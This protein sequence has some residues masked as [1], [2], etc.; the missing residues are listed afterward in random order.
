M[1][2][3]QLSSDADLLDTSLREWPIPVQRQERIISYLWGKGSTYRKRH[4]R[5]YFEYYTEQC[6]IATQ[7]YQGLLVVKTHQHI[8]NI[9]TR[10]QAGDSRSEVQQFVA[11][12]TWTEDQTSEKGIDASIDLTVRLLYMIDVG[13]LENAYSGREK[14]LW[15]HGNLQDFM[16]DTFSECTSLEND[17]TRLDK[18]FQ[19]CNMIRI[20]GFQVEPTSNIC[21]H[22]RFTD[23]SKTVEGDK[24]TEKWYRKHNGPEEL[25]PNIVRCGK[26]SKQ[27]EDYKYWHD[28]L[29]VLKR[30]F[31]HSR[32]SN[33][34][35]WWNDR[36]DASQWYP[37]WVAISLTVL[38]GLVQSV[39][40]ALQV[41]KAYKP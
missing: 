25:D 32:P 18:T 5:P 40:G 1:Q 37:L 26:I 11:R 22:L 12:S 38:F 19:V 24:E 6:T 14:R 16:R 10:I 20:A 13:Q 33:M 9:A 8:I 39:E 31:D 27:I 36:R 17:G 21:D 29:I 15:T 35:Q 2:T 4:L 23:M 28:R 3:I 30:E 41:Y 34:T 7:S